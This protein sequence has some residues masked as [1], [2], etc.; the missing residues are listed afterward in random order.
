MV[1]QARVI[2]KVAE[3]CGTNSGFMSSC[4][5]HFTNVYVGWKCHG[6]TRSLKWCVVSSSNS[7][8]NTTVRK[9]EMNADFCLLETDRIWY[10]S[11]KKMSWKADN[12]PVRFIFFVLSVFS[13]FYFYFFL[14]KDKLFHCWHYFIVLLVNFKPFTWQQYQRSCILVLH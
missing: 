5:L 3:D 9:R 14:F 11:F 12:R 1:L 13:H 7:T 8:K 4:F 6:D 10:S 2:F